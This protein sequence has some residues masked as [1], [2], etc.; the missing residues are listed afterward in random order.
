MRNTHHLLHHT[1]NTSTQ[2]TQARVTK[3]KSSGLKNPSSSAMRKIIVE[4]VPVRQ[5]NKIGFG[6]SPNICANCSAN[7]GDNSA[8]EN[9]K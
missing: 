5:Y 8:P 4:R 6:A 9:G 7:V 1:P 3:R 2:D